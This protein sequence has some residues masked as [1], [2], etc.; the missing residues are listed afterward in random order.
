MAEQLQFDTASVQNWYFE[1]GI[2]LNIGKIVSFT[3]KLCIPVLCAHFVK[4]FGV[5]GL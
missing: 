3:Y 5:V 4:D 1:N 2:I